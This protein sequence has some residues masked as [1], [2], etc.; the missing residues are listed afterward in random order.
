MSFPEAVGDPEAVV[1]SE[2]VY[3]IVESLD[4]EEPAEGEYS[5]I[6]NYT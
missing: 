2:V 4:E 6:A 3:E 5:T 1:D